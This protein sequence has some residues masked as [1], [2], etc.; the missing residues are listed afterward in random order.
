MSTLEIT[1]HKIYRL[2]DDGTREP[3]A[4]IHHCD[5]CGTRGYDH[6]QVTYEDVCAIRRPNVAALGH[7]SFCDD[8]FDDLADLAI[9]QVILELGQR[10]TMEETS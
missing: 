9:A 2:D 4:S 3:L 6:D 7:E 1:D 8:C 10:G 5:R